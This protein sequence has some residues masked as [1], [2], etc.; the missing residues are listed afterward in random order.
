VGELRHEGEE[1]ENIQR[2]R[3]KKE[4]KKGRMKEQL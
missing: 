2:K 3:E 4:G 1:R